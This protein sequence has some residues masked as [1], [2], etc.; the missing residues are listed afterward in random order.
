MNL[1][2]SA[3]QI[4]RLIKRNLGCFLV[5][6]DIL[7]EGAV[8]VVRLLLDNGAEFEQLVWDGLVC[9]LENVDQSVLLAHIREMKSELTTRSAPCPGQ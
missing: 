6:V 8:H 5:H 3:K 2:A 7:E 1:H 9:A 4:S